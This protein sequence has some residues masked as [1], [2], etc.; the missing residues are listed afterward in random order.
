MKFTCGVAQG[1]WFG[2]KIDVQ[3]LVN[4]QRWSETGDGEV[5]DVLDTG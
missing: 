3:V 1:V 2:I 5:T 4:S